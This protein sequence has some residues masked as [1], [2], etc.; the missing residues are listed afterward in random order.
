MFLFIFQLFIY[1]H[2]EFLGDSK[3]TCKFYE[4][5]AQKKFIELNNSI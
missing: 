5:Y 3:S 4:L 1:Y 2:T